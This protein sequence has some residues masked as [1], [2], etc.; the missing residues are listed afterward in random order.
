M[1][2]FSS[3]CHECGKSIKAPYDLPE[4]NKWMNEV[5][6]ISS[7]GILIKGPYDGYGRIGNDL[8]IPD[9]STWRHLRCATKQHLLL[10][11]YCGRSQQAND[12]GFFDGEQGP[13]KDE[14][15]AALTI[16]GE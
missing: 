11:E 6:T 4:A 14:V 12:Q 7:D 15:I 9:D 10:T 16:G 2:F 5:I 3:D 1:G 8:E 13:N